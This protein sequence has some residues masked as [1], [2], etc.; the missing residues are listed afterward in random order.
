[1]I[2]KTLFSG[3]GGNCT[4]LKVGNTEI[5]IDAGGSTKRIECA[6]RELDTSLANISAIY[7][8]HEHSDHV[9]SLPVLLRAH[10]IPV[11]ITPES[12]RCMCTDSTRE[13]FREY[14]YT[15]DPGKV[16]ETG[17]IALIPFCTPHDSVMSVGYRICAGDKECLGY[18][19]DTGHVT[20]TMRKFLSGC[21]RVVVESNHD[22]DM[23]KNGPYPPYLKKRILAD[24]GHLSNEC[25]ANF[26]CDLVD[27][28]CESIMLAHL[29]KEN[30]TPSA[31]YN[32]AKNALEQHGV[33]IGKD[34]NLA[35]AAEKCICDIC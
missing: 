30:N 32:T 25:C 28:G 2:F 24:T 27:S 9:S 20:D 21:K 5:L 12:A 18:A 6:L 3:S 29:S 19:T 8:T 34:V 13:L 17:D 16:Y 35:V 23:L 33:K 31:A 14:F 22:V 11:Y 15:I 4:Y 26:L 7:I 1:M 10:G